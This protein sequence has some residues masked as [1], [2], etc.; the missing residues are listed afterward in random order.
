MT[1][2]RAQLDKLMMPVV[3]T[4]KTGGG[5]DNNL[6]ADSAPAVHIHKNASRRRCQTEKQGDPHTR[7]KVQRCFRNQPLMKVQRLHSG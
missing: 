1:R 6:K 4:K 2:F 3:E 5:R 7:H